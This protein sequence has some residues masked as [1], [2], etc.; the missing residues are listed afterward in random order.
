MKEGMSAAL[1]VKSLL[2]AYILWLS[3]VGP[4]NICQ[5]YVCSKPFLANKKQDWL[6]L[7]SGIAVREF[8]YCSKCDYKD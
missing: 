8:W 2:S 5:L 7:F 3:V 4:N 6:I 1:S